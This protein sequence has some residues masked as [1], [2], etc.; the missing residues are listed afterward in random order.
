MQ[1]RVVRRDY[2]WVRVDWV[3]VFVYPAA[4]VTALTLLGICLIQAQIMNGWYSS[5]YV[6]VVAL[7]SN[8]VCIRSGIVAA[9]LASLEHEFCFAGTIWSLNW[10]SPEQALSYLSMFGAAYVVGRKIPVYQPPAE[11]GPRIDPLPFT[12]VKKM[13]GDDTAT[14]LFWHVD[15]TGL[16]GD[17]SQLGSEYGRIYVERLRSKMPAPLLGHVVKDMIGRGRFTGIEAGFMSA[18]SMAASGKQPTPHL[19]TQDHTD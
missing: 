2:T 3:S 6:A 16:W 1:A 12:A 13:D 5:P 11:R 4:F 7:I 19:L 17:D 10:P 14:R 9:A 18:I 15:E 8:R